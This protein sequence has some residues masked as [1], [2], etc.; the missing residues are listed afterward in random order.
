MNA[1]PSSA[2]RM[3]SV[4]GYLYDLYRDFEHATAEDLRWLGRHV[5][6][7][8]LATLVRGLSIALEGRAK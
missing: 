3:E 7:K 1:R 8:R 6:A 5:P 2:E 4:A